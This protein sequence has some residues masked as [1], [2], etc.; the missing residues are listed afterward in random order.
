MAVKKHNR[1]KKSAQGKAYITEGRALK[2][3]KVKIARHKKDH[4]N[5]KQT[6]GTIPDYTSKKTEGYLF[7]AIPKGV[8]KTRK[9]V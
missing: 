7:G 2:N 9:R 1:N 4:P 6:V 8:S 3:K 5:D